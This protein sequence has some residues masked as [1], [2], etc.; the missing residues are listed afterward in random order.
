VIGPEGVIYIAHAKKLYAI[1]GGNPPV[2]SA[3]PMFRGGPRHSARSPQRGLR[4][5]P[6]SVD[7]S[8]P[9]TVTTEVGSL[10]SLQVSTNLTDWSDTIT[11]TSTNRTMTFT[12]PGTNGLEFYRLQAP[13][14]SPE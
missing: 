12:Q 14:I 10:Y 11:F 1:Q 2:R 5:S 7:G 4:S 8:I 13:I 9:L 3:W 6:P